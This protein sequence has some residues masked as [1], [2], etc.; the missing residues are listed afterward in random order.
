MRGKNG[1]GKKEHENIQIPHTTADSYRGEQQEDLNS[2]KVIQV[3]GVI[4]AH[5]IQSDHLE[6]H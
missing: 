2:K 1:N 6:S 5:L 3:N 4:W